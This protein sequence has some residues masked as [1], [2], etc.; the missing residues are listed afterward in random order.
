MSSIAGKARGDDLSRIKKNALKYAGVEVDRT[1]LEED[2]TKRGFKSLET[3]RL[4][5][6]I[7]MLDK[8]DEDPY[9]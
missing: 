8:F 1:E 2:K 5:C 9:K 7:K 3:G 4:L 6:P